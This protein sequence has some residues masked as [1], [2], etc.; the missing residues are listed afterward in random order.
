M[1]DF[2]DGD[3]KFRANGDEKINWGG[4]SFPHGQLIR[5][6]SNIPLKKG[7]YLVEIDL[8]KNTYSFVEA[9]D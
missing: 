3:V 9:G 4:N 5:A 6:G 2:E 1:V 8:D 7:K